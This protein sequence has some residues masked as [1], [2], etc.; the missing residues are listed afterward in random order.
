MTVLEKDS[1]IKLGPAEEIPPL[2]LRHLRR[3]V[4]VQSGEGG[5]V[6]DV[7]YVRFSES[8]LRRI[9]V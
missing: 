3:D 7:S 1:L 5:E 2:V 9:L 6:G 4:L 8:I